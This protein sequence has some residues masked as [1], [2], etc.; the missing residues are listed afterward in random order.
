MFEVQLG[1]E[2]VAT[3]Q[4]RL[5]DGGYETLHHHRWTVQVAVRGP[6]TDPMGL[7]IDFHWLR[8][9][10]DHVLDPL[11]ETNLNE[12][13]VLGPINPTAEHVARYIAEQLKPALPLLVQLVRVTVGEA[14]GCWASFLPERH[15]R[16][17]VDL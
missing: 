10:L 17:D 6:N 9:L 8:Q 2:F 11:R 13:A 7:L 1:A 15:R 12:H 14:A 4:I 16:D 5:A 3:H